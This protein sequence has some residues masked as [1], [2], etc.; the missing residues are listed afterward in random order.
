MRLSTLLLLML[1]PILGFAQS[2]EELQ[3]QRDEL[4]RKI[5]YTKKL[6]ADTKQGQ[7]A[8]FNDLRIL[9]EQINYR[10]QLLTSYE[11]EIRRFGDEIKASENQIRE[12]ESKIARMKEEY[13]A[14]I[15]QAYKNRRNHD[16]LMY[17]FAAKDFNQAFKRFKIL[18]EYADYRK[19]QANEIRDTQEQLRVRVVELEEARKEK[20]ALLSTKA[21]E[22]DELA[23]DRA[24]SESVLAELKQKESELR[25]QQEQQEAERQRLNAAIRRIIEEE[26]AAEKRKNDGKFELTP[27]G[28]IVSAEFEKN[29]GSLPWPVVRGVVTS[30]FGTQPHESIPGITIENNG[31]DIATEDG[32]SVLAIFNGEVTSV[33]SIPGAGKN[34]IVTHGAYKSVYTNLTEVTVKKGQTVNAGEK[35][36]TVITAANKTTAHLEIWKMSSSGPAPQNPELWIK[37]N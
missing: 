18:Q 7:E 11:K 12:L 1:L 35:L 34:V 14:M 4:N 15:R 28:R 3:R 23:A 37:K 21:A 13:A 17:I 22:A 16:E 24:Q 29:K 5:E 26:L 9:K 19:R 31:V 36:G 2:K 6:I 25:R 27:E 30:R 33:F 10:R 8:T 20:E 32:A